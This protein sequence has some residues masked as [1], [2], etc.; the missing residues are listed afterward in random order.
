MVGV[1]PPTPRKAY[2]LWGHWLLRG[3]VQLLNR[4]LVISEI[5]LATN[6]DDWEAL[7]KVQD[8]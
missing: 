8:F 2:L 7:A 3:L 5:L 4:L 1:R 6:E